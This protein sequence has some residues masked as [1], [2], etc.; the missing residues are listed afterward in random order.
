MPIG[1]LLVGVGDLEYQ[2]F[3]EFPA[4]YLE[5]D[6][7]LFSFFFQKTTWYADPANPCYVCG[8]GENVGE[9]H[10]E[11]VVCALTELK[12]RSRR[13]RADNCIDLLKGSSEIPTDQCTNLLG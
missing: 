10:A 8:Q 11:R 6:G 9:I 5:T 13:C 1:A 3:T 7:K 2:R 4:E 12:R